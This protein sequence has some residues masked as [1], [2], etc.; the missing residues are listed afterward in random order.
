MQVWVLKNLIALKTG[1]PRKSQCLVFDGDIMDD[2][3][4]I[5]EYS[6]GLDSVVALSVTPSPSF[7]TC[8]S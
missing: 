1:A 5:G 7:G 2:Y 4:T 8:C 6:L 3:K